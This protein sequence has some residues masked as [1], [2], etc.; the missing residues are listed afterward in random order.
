MHQ[1]EKEE[2]KTETPPM[3]EDAGAAATEGT[4]QQQ[5][6]P[7][8]LQSALNECQE[9]LEAEKKKVRI[10]ELLS[11]LKKDRQRQILIIPTFKLKY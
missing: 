4:E 9:N 10:K 8:E 7:E 6:S 1:G 5:L 2:G 11:I 3:E